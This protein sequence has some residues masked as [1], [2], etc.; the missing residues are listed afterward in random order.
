MGSQQTKEGLTKY[1]QLSYFQFAKIQIEGLKSQSRC[2]CSFQDALW[3]VQ[4]SKGL[5]P[6][7]QIELL[8]TGRITSPKAQVTRSNMVI[9]FHWFSYVYVYIYIYIY[10]Y[11]H[12]YIYTHMYTYTHIHTYIYI[13]ICIHMYR[14]RDVFMMHMT[15][16][17]TVTLVLQI[18]TCNVFTNV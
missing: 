15:W 12:I 6:L 8:K 3:K 9:S 13:Y 10:M 7:F 2:L 14:E 5:G 11:I 18:N 16:L 4:S 1:G 17:F